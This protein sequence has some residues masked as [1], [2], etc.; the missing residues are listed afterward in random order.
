MLESRE[1]KMADENRVVKEDINK[2][3]TIVKNHKEHIERLETKI[4]KLE[5]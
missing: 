2:L 4:K 3:F 1:I 5:K